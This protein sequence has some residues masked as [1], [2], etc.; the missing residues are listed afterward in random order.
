MD[1][2]VRKSLPR[3]KCVRK[4]Y[5]SCPG[6]RVHN[7]FVVVAWASIN[8]DQSTSDCQSWTLWMWVVMVLNPILRFAFLFCNSAS[9]NSAPPKARGTGPARAFVFSGSK[10]RIGQVFPQRLSFG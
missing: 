2:L 4:R 7:R 9:S 5:T 8:I 1:L 3:A 10:R 6:L